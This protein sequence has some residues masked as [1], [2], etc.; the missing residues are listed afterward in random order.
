VSARTR[1]CVCD[2]VCVCVCE[3]VCVC[4]CVC[5]CD[6]VCVCVCARARAWQRVI[7]CNDVTG[8][9]LAGMSTLC[10]DHQLTLTCTPST[11][12]K[13]ESWQ[14]RLL[15]LG[16]ACL[17]CLD[18]VLTSWRSMRACAGGCRLQRKARAVGAHRGQAGSGPVFSVQ[19]GF[20]SN[21]GDFPRSPKQTKNSPK[22]W[23]LPGLATA[24]TNDRRI[25]HAVADGT[26]A[27]VPMVDARER[28]ERK[29]TSAPPCTQAWGKVGLERRSRESLA[30]LVHHTEGNLV[31]CVD[32]PS[33]QRVN[34]RLVISKRAENAR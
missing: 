30:C 28:E 7:G 4:V 9:R 12:L 3:S 32:P 33:F 31:L 29:G 20:G 18:L 26:T 16:V 5:V 1:A 11:R 21:R 13:Q 22:S 2:S 6:S 17:Q 14:K 10:R 8:V 27:T 23:K 24:N 34:V 25:K 19:S 15:S